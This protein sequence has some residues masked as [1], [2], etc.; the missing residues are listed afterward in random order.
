MNSITVY[1]AEK[2]DFYQY[3]SQTLEIMKAFGIDIRKFILI[4]NESLKDIPGFG[5][6][7]GMEIT[8]ENISD[9]IVQRISENFVGIFVWK[10]GV[11]RYY[12]FGA[13]VL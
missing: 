12:H 13:R 5:N 6:V 9:A 11:N 8:A 4:H 3:S 1:T 10:H 2:D 7:L